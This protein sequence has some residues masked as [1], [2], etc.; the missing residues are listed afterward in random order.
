MLGFGSQ[1]VISIPVDS[2]GHMIPSALETS[3]KEAQAKGYTPFYLNATAGTTVLGSFDPFPALA[4][5]CRS[6]N[7]WFHIDAS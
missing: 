4:Q 3:I 5:I 1:S 6:H 2:H 7:L